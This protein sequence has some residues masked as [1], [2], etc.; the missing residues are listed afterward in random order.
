MCEIACGLNDRRESYH[1][2][3][4]PFC[5]SPRRGR[6]K[7]YAGNHYEKRAFPNLALLHNIKGELLVFCQTR[8]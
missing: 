2:Q 7:Y 4:K 8:T 1:P 6:L 5:V 3:R